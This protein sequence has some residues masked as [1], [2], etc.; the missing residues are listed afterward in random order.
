MYALVV[1]PGCHLCEQAEQSMTEL[2]AELGIVWCS[3]D[4]DSDPR[5]STYS[6]DLPVLLREGRPIA[7]LTSSKSAL[8]RALKPPLWH[9]LRNSL[10]IN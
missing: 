5:Y 1:R 8:A 9:R 7:R 2:E 3:Q 10:H 6:D 4:I